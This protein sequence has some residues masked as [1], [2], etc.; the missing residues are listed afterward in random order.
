[1]LGMGDPKVITRRFTSGLK[2]YVL[3]S[4]YSGGG[5]SRRTYCSRV[6]LRTFQNAIAP[7]ISGSCTAIASVVSL[8]N[9]ARPANAGGGSPASTTAPVIAS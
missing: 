2:V 7:A 5:V 4:R 9:P 8:T 3:P 6:P 1:M